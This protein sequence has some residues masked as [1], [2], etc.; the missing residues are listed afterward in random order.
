MP[1]CPPG[2]CCRLT[3]YLVLCESLG[4][5]L[6]PRSVPPLC[7]W[8]EISSVMWTPYS[9]PSLAC[10]SWASVTICWPTSLPAWSRCCCKTITYINSGAVRQLGNLTRLDLDDNRIRA[11][12]SLNKL[13]ALTPSLNHLDLS[14]NC[15]S[16]L[17]LPSFST[18]VN[19]QDLKST[20]TL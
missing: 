3:G 11:L 2:C 16:V 10:R 8:P 5:Q 6:L 18:L 13:Q 19:L 4:L 20:V 9:S 7:L 1:P 17:D 12:Q 14:A 15:I